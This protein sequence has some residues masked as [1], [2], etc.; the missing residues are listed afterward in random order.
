MGHSVFVI[1]NLFA[2]KK[3]H[4]PAGVQFRCLDLAD[5]SETD[6]CTAVRNISP[7]YV[8]HLAAIHYIPY[9]LSHPR[10]TFDVNVR[11]TELVI[12]A[13]ESIKVQR[14]VLASTA[15]VYAVAD[16]PHHENDRPAPGNVYGLSKLLSE[17]ILAYAIRAG[18]V[19]SGVA[20][21][22]FNI[23]GPR[24]TNLHF[25]PRVM[26]Q[27]NDQSLS[28]LRFGYLGAS[29]DF[30]YVTDV[31]DAIVRSLFSNIVGY[32]CLNV[33]TGKPTR[34]RD[35]LA[36]L[37]DLYSDDRVVVEDDARFRSF[38]RKSLTADVT[39]ISGKLGWQP[40]VTVREGL[41][42]LVELES[43]AGIVSQRNVL[44]ADGL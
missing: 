1:D 9:C 18:I 19:K 36:I 7:D 35:V 28:E 38:E 16:L 42:M 15:D 10:E 44:N 26:E 22:F 37:Q 25:I 17:E 14:V 33:G 34:V 2:G 31:V 40:Q 3:H 12:R 11:G 6:Y 39:K 32:E 43:R 27:L 41:R 5:I 8:V 29:R 20:L 24:E 4:I 30:I 23:Y 21:R 13:L